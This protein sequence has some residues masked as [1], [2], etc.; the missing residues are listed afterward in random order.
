MLISPD[1]TFC[2]ALNIH[3]HD[4]KNRFPCRHVGHTSGSHWDYTGL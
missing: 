2:P 1:K 3:S 4:V